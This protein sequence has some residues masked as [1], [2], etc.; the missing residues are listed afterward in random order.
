M[1]RKKTWAP[2]S[3]FAFQDAIASVCGF[4][5]LLALILALELTNQIADE[6]AEPVPPPADLAKL[7]VEI[8]T[9][10]K[11]LAA[12]KKTSE[13]WD[14]MSLEA[15]RSHFSLENAEA[16]LRAA[17]RR[18]TESLTENERLQALIADASETKASRDELPR[19]I[20]KQKAEIADLDKQIANL[21]RQTLSRSSSIYYA[22]TNDVRETPWLV[23]VADRRIIVCSLKSETSAP[24]R[25]VEFSGRNARSG[26]L[27]WARRRDPDA[28]Y[29]VLVVRPSGVESY[30]YLRYSL[31]SDGF[32]IGID[33]VGETSTLEI[34]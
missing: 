32:K 14:K 15:S 9:L 5:V 23:D 33:L 20:K 11:D 21:R 4:V 30:P 34:D 10:K 7:T 2:F 18:L 22:S 6:A 12:L 3:L 25:P 29:F 19:K 8:S 28:E 27:A 1:R 24:E 13:L 31:E 16:E 26:F 17:E